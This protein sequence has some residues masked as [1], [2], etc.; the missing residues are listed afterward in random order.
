MRKEQERPTVK[1]QTPDFHM[2]CEALL[3]ILS[4]RGSGPKKR[5]NLKKKPEHPPTAEPTTKVRVARA[6]WPSTEQT[7]RPEATACSCSKAIVEA[8]VGDDVLLRCICLKN[9]DPYLAWQ[10]GA[11]IVVDH[12][13]P[14]YEEGQNPQFKGRTRLF[15]HEDAG[16]CSLWLSKVTLDDAKTYT[17]HYKDPVYTSSNITLR[18]RGNI[19]WS[20][21]GRPSG[22]FESGMGVKVSCLQSVLSA[23]S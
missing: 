11:D 6:I 10:I 7:I 13:I 21:S 5:G 9:E 2:S 15:L 17:C 4:E 23:I 14:G 20:S 19:W 16:N 18:L 22:S 3:N 12:Y 8:T 1:P